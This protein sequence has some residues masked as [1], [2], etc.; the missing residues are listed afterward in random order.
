MRIEQLE[1]L[2]E[3]S[4]QNSMKSAA[5]ILHM[6][7]QALSSTIKTLEDE[8]SI[9]IFHRSNKGISPTEDGKEI[10]QFAEL[11]VDN[12]YRLLQKMNRG[13]QLSNTLKGSLMLYVAPVFL[14]SIFPSYI[15]KF[16]SNYPKVTVEIIQRSTRNICDALSQ[17]IADNTLGAIIVPYNGKDILYDYLPQNYASLSFQILNRN[18]YCACVPKDSPLARQKTVSIKKLLSSYPLIDYCA[19]NAGTA[20]LVPLLKAYAPKFQTSL[21]LSSIAV[22]AEAIQN[23]MGI[24]FINTLFTKPDSIIANQ[25]ENLALLQLKEPLV[26]FNCFVHTKTP[27]PAVSIF[28]KQFPAYLP[29]KTDP[30]FLIH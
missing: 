5:E 25:L 6:T 12:Y 21:V 28:L 24:G 8:L 13:G 2:L 16:K 18:Y 4:R 26:T 29:Q 3:I 7:P 23:H 15:T 1:Y 9:K 20:P 19:G 14:E 17:T 30:E 27:S 10:L 11:V 22:W